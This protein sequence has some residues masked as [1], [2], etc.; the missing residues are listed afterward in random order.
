MHLDPYFIKAVM[1]D[2]EREAQRSRQ[3][4]QAKRARNEKRKPE[5]G[6]RRRLSL[7]N[8]LQA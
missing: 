2:R 1:A 6:R 5:S 7:R 4:R 8:P 3:A